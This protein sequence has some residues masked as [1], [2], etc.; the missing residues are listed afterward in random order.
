MCTVLLPPGV[1]LLQLKYKM[2]LNI[3]IVFCTITAT[4]T[5][6]SPTFHGHLSI[7]FST[8]KHKTV[9]HPQH[10]VESVVQVLKKQQGGTKRM[11]TSN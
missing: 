11:S 3:A 1:N 10:C 5:T 6:N 2:I 7:V 4:L 8:D 9:Q